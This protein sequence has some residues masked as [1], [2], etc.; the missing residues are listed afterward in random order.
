MEV[1]RI[2]VSLAAVVGAIACLLSLPSRGHTLPS[3]VH[4]RMDTG[5]NEHELNLKSLYDAEKKNDRYSRE[6]S[7]S[8]LTMAT[9]SQLP[10][11]E[12]VEEEGATEGSEGSGAEVQAVRCDKLRRTRSQCRT[13]KER[14]VEYFDNNGQLARLNSFY[15]AFV[16]E[17]IHHFGLL[18]RV[19]NVMPDSQRTTIFGEDNCAAILERR[20]GLRNVSAGIC[21]WYYTCSY[22]PNSLPRFR[23]E[24]RLFDPTLHTRQFC[25]E[26]RMERVTYFV[27]E[28]CPCGGENWKKNETD[29]V[30]GYE[31]TPTAHA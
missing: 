9:T 14:L 18:G 19:F 23:I 3:G 25:E 28:K 29:I 31:E 4:Q 2:F 12:P 15:N 6:T 13:L 5:L 20:Y 27:R 10:L 17:D 24:A 16:L 22:N 1:R 8:V 7:E 26:V 30:V 11:P 21:S